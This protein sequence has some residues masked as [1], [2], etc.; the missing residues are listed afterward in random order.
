MDAVR[1]SRRHDA[2]GTNIFVLPASQPVVG[3]EAAFRADAPITVRA[4]INFRLLLRFYIYQWQYVEVRG[5]A[6]IGVK[7][8]RA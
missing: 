5:K 7:S 2:F 4:L 6:M 8:D 3:C 1:R